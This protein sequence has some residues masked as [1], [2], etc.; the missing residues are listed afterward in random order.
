MEITREKVMKAVND[1]TR[2]EATEF[3]QMVVDYLEAQAKLPSEKQKYF[4]SDIANEVYDKLFENE[5]HADL[6]F[7]WG[8]P[9]AEVD[10]ANARIYLNDEFVIKIERV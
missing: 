3:M 4:E 9:N 8:F 1:M 7:C 6:D 2:E 5:G 10:T